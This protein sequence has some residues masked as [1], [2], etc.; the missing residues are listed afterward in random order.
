MGH[1]A[2]DEHL[3][4]AVGLIPA[5][6]ARQSRGRTCSARQMA[7]WTGRRIVEMVSRRT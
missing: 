4:E 7:Y 1:G 3:V 2:L 5:A 6:A